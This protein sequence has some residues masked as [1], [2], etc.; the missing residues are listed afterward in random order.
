MVERGTGK[1]INVASLLSFQ[2]GLR[3]TSYAATKHAVAGLTRALANEWAASRRAGERDR[4]RLHRHRQHPRAARGRR[5]LPGDHR[6]DPGRPLGRP[7]PTWSAP[8]SSSRRRH[9]TTSTDT[10]SSSTAA[11]P[12]ADHRSQPPALLTH[13]APSTSSRPQLRSTHVKEATSMMI[14]HRRGTRL[15]PLLAALAAGTIVL[16]GCGEDG[17]TETTAGD[18]AACKP[19][20]VKLIGQ[21]RNQTNP[22]E[23]AW[24]EGGDDV[25]RDRS[26]SSSQ[27]HLRRRVRQAAGPDPAGAGHRRRARAPS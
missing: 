27:A 7:R 14:R 4:A 18:G 15:A 10:C 20:D 8:P 12:P 23:A 19:E 17:G 26:T 21:V 11:G 22:Y 16:A 6:T 13:S 3:V 1:V 25:R 2:G 9:P 5:T 24:L